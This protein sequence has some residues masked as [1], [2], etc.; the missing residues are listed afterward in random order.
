MKVLKIPA[1]MLIPAVFSLSIVGVYAVNNSIFDIYLL[2][3]F[4]LIG[5]VLVHFQVPLA[6]IVLGVILGPMA[7]ENL[8]L[9]LLIGQNEWTALFPSGLSIGLAIFTGLVVLFSVFKPLA[10]K[11]LSRKRDPS[12][13]KQQLKTSANHG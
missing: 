1:A 9:A 11:Y 13:G 12:D 10:G 7:E 4:G 5:V 6:P 8:R 2:L 3:V